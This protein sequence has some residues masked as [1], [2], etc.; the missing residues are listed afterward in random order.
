MRLAQRQPGFGLMGCVL[1]A[2]ALSRLVEW[3]HWNTWA[4]W[5]LYALL[6]FALDYS[7][8]SPGQKPN[9]RRSKAAL[10]FSLVSFWL[11]V[12]GLPAYA[13]VLILR[14]PL[15][16]WVFLVPIV[17]GLTFAAYFRNRSQR[18]ALS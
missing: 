4:F 16:R 18:S 8:F 1:I 11:T 13:V 5:S 12:I 7:V 3:L 14:E 17:L 9:E 2:V 15:F 10:I 6:L